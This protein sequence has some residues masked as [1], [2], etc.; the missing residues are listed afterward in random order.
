MRLIYCVNCDDIFNPINHDR[1][2]CGNTTA[3]MVDGVT[4]FNGLYAVPVE[5]GDASMVSSL[6]YYR[7]F[8]VMTRFSGWFPTES[9][10]FRKEG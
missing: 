3:V 8:G 7:K 6:E 2:M 10:Y 5:L 1:C 4:V 9:N